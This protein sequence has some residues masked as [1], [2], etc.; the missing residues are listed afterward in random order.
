VVDMMNEAGEWGIEGVWG[1]SAERW[2][3]DGIN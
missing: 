2:K 3:K 1:V